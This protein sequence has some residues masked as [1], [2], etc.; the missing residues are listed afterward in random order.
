[1]CRAL[2][3]DRCHR[4]TH[5]DRLLG[6]FAIQVPAGTRLTAADSALIADV[7]AHAGLLLL[8]ALL[9]VQ[10][11]RQVDE[12]GQLLDHSGPVAASERNAA[13]IFSC[14]HLFFVTNGTSTSNKMV[15]HSMPTISSPSAR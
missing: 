2:A 11:T 9:G 3:A 14:D 13:R 10:L 15:W 8:N 1:M 4:I 12:L 6:F 5:H 7:A